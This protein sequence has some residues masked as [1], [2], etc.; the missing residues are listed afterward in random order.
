MAEFTL[1]QKLEFHYDPAEQR[2]PQWLKRKQGKIGASSVWRWLAVSKA[3]GK[4]GTPLKERLDYEKELMFERQF[5]TSFEVFVSGAMQDGID[6][7][8]FAAQQFAEEFGFEIAEVGCWYNHFMAVSPDRIVFPKGNGIVYVN[9]TDEMKNALGV[10]EV[11]VVKDNT[12]TEILMSGVPDK[13]MKQMQSQLKATGLTKGWYV[14]LNFN[15]KRYVVIEVEA[16]TEFHEYLMEAIQ[17]E[18]V[19]EPFAL[20]K[21]HEIKGEIPSGVELGADIDRSDSNIDPAGF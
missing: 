1:E 16:D 7:E 15:T 4:E 11:K 9:N 14:A 5:N 8:A 18:L 2:S 12:F 13:H 20:D 21:V 17:E 6:Y 10:A 3:K 19:A